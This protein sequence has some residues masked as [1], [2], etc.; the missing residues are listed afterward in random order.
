MTRPFSHVTPLTG[1]FLGTKSTIFKHDKINKRHIRQVQTLT[2]EPP[3]TSI[4]LSTTY[5]TQYNSSTMA[6]VLVLYCT[7]IILSTVLCQHC[8]IPSSSKY[9]SITL[10]PFFL[11]LRSSF[12]EAVHEWPLPT[13]PLATPLARTRTTHTTHLIKSTTASHAAQVSAP[14][15]S[16]GHPTPRRR[17]LH[18]T[19]T[20]S[21]QG[22]RRIPGGAPRSQ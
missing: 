17:R 13:H 10:L 14:P 22:P 20:R 18:C 5:C 1:F 21:P 15:P 12:I 16:G 3:S 8:S 9:R 4:I 2:A 6:L 11:D 7:S 19:C